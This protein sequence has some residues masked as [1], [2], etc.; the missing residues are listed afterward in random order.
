[1]ACRALALAALAIALAP[2][3]PAAADLNGLLGACLTR[4]AADGNTG[5]GLQLPFRFCD[6]GTPDFGGT[7]ANPTAAKAVAVPAAY[8]GAG[9]PVKDAAAAVTVPGNA[10]GNVALDVD[11]SLPDPGSTPM[12]AAGYPVIVMMHG[13]CSG[14]RSSWEDDSVDGGGERWHYN[15]A[16]FASRGYIVVNYTARGFVDG[17]GHGSTGETQ[18]DSDRF[19]INDFQHLV[20]QLADKGDLDPVTAGVQKANPQRIAATGGSYGGGFS[21][22]AVTD[23]VWHSPGGT[24]MRLAAAAPRYGWT[25]LLESLVPNGADPRDA[26]PTTDPAKAGQPTGF[27]KRSIVTAL[28]LSGKT[29]IPPGSSHTTFP[30][31]IDA[32]EACLSSFD[33]P[34]SNPLCTSTL[35]TTLPRFLNERSAYFENGFF[36]GL[37]SG[38]IQ[39]VPIFSAGTLTDPLFPPAEHRRMVERLKA[40]VP[41]YPVQE[42]YG[43]YQHFEQNKAKEWGDV[44]G[45]DRH[46]CRYAD[47][48][49]GDLDQ[50]PPGLA[51]EVGATTRLNRFLDHYLQPPADP[52]P[53]TPARDVTASLQVC[54]NY[55]RGAIAD[56]PGPRFTA[57]SFL[58]LAPNSLTI[59]A[60]GEQ[61]APNAVLPN[62]HAVHADPVGS[63]ASN[64]SQCILEDSPNGFASAGPGVAT[65]DSDELP[66]DFTM[67][68]RTRLTVLHS[69]IGPVTQLNARLYDLAPDG[70]QVMVDRGVRRLTSAGGPTVLDLHGNGWRFRKGDR[71][72]VEIAQDDDPYVKKS[73]Q[74]STLMISSAKLELPIREAS[75]SLGGSVPP[76]GPVADLRAPRLAS[77]QG[78][79]R[80]F[81]V[82]LRAGRRRDRGLIDHYELQARDTRSRRWRRLSTHLKRSAYRL[83]GKLGR[84]YLLRARAVDGLGRK[85]PWDTERTIVPLDDRSRAIH[86]RGAWRRVKARR[87]WGRRLH[88][89]LRRRASLRLRFR[90][91]RLYLI[92]RRSR[93]GGKARVVVNG[94]RRTVR[95]R[96]RRTRNRQLVLRLRTKRRGLNR[97][98]LVVLSGRVEIDGI[99]FRR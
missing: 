31:D 86:Y 6:D 78:T 77:T 53:P 13:C 50:T 89:A 29:G 84:N 39:P 98:R 24:S 15:N 38:S 26:L 4:D 34:E 64:S 67:I 33:P 66:S 46:V 79:S 56:E 44:C 55:P 1:M 97:L 76:A 45:A 32:A 70:T 75:T 10:G 54:E 73:V 83:R 35:A 49:G 51:R 85:G 62:P 47:Y 30:P 17:D 8:Q 96:S 27:P 82:R 68:G 92:G 61:A 48:P 2:A 69:G 37:R 21:W 71:V 42:Y 20:G 18:L 65:Y 93:R 36:A 25:N 72:R 90:G 57:P 19:E 28:Y 22:M 9:E 41:N 58:Q 94:R 99:G 60:A 7:T 80:R 12:P 14:S 95:F 16:W 3:A 87:A 11:V 52:S 63:T 88:R 91:D 81:R 40:S 59:S 5:N 23:P 74:A 43:D